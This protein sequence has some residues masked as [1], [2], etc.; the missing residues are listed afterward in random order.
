MQM[1]NNY[2]QGTRRLIRLLFRQHR[3]KIVLWMTGIVGISLAVAFLYPGIY[4][5]PDD[6]LGYALTMEN[7]A[8]SALIGANYAV[9]DYNVAVI[10]ATEMLLFTAIAAAIMNILVMKASTRG[11][12]EEGRL[13]VVQSLPVG[14][15]SYLVASLSLL[16]LV[17]F[18]TVFL[19]TIGLTAFGAEVF[20][21]ESSLL[22]STILGVTGFLFASFTAIAAQLSDTTY[23]TTALSIGFLLLSYAIRVIGDVQNETLSLFSPLGWVTRTGV[24]ADDNWLPVFVL[25]GG[26]VLFVVLAFYLRARRDMFAGI[27][28]NRAGKGRASAFL[29][30]VPG[31]VWTLERGKVI[32]W[33]LLIFLLSAAFG[34]ILGEMETYFSNMEIV[35]VFLE[36]RSG[37]TITEQ[38]VTLLIQIMTIFSLIPGVTILHSL[39]GEES[40]G[41]V[42]HFYTRAVSRNNLLLTYFSFALGTVLLMQLG[43]A[44][45]LYATSARVLENPMALDQLIESTLV[46]LPA[47][48][49]VLGLSVLLVGALPKFTL[50]SWLY[51]LLMFIV[52]YLGDLLEFPSW[53][54]GFSALHHI[55]EYPHESIDWSVMSILSGLGV[56]F[57][58][59]GFIGYNRRDIQS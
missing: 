2:F 55:P 52:L 3:L 33:F 49:L 37:G 18:A 13:E 14:K 9:A 56:L 7:P 35:Q 11:D 58:L 12:E 21:F 16:F 25:A 10:Y 19:L 1:I 28:P 27:L 54:N 17:N 5:T 39:K 34:A 20:T 38:F 29:K 59:F 22:Y 26:S 8:M 47:I 48:L 45:G 23:G 24:F 42:E 53:L 46:Y 31:L 57:A 6:I 4:T 43:T 32:G 15:L 51:I 41:R 36:N 44:L 50:L 40:A 30:T